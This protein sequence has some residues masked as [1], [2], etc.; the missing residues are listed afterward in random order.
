M[1]RISSEALGQPLFQGKVENWWDFCS[2]VDTPST[3]QETAVEGGVTATAAHQMYSQRQATGSTGA[4]SLDSRQRHSTITSS[5]HI[6]IQ[7]SSQQEWLSCHFPWPRMGFPPTGPQPQE[8]QRCLQVLTT[9]FL[10]GH[11]E[12]PGNYGLCT[13]ATR[14]QC[15][16]TESERHAVI[17]LKL[18]TQ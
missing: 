15:I 14:V 4:T 1:A 5:L 16:L 11:P 8:A 9:W 7:T 17:V 12:G 18:K 2:A 3:G 10:L 13:L 6:C